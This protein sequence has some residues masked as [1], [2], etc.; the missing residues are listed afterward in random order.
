QQLDRIAHSTMLGLSNPLAIDLAERL[1]KL[2]PGGLNR[3]FYSDSGSEAVEIAL[4]IAYQHHVIRGE[5]HRSH[6]LTLANGYHGDTIGAVSVGGIAQFHALFKPLLF[7]T[8]WGPSPGML[9]NGFSR[10]DAA[11]EPFVNLLSENADRLAAVILEPMIQA[12]GG[13]AL[14]PPGFLK[15]VERACREFGVLLIVDEVATGFGR[16]GRMFACEHE[17]VHPDLMCLAKGITGG[18]LPLAAT[19]VT[20]AVFEPFRTPDSVFFHGHSY[21]G[22]AL[23]CA[24]ALANLDLFEENRVIECLAPKIDLIR[25]RLAPVTELEHVAE[26]RRL[27]MMIGIEIINDKAGRIPYPPEQGMGAQ[28]CRRARDLGMITRPLGDVVVFMPPLSSTEEELNAMLDILIQAL[29][30]TTSGSDTN[31]DAD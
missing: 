30:D 24:A 14:M 6:Y 22:N 13:M 4:K 18:Y 3:V 25:R 31:G 26:V 2:A 15:G 19:L 7:Q 29:V 20:D 28:V 11:L 21:T 5:R 23:G 8:H 10:P 1:V 27:G 17:D 9:E 16:T 12:A